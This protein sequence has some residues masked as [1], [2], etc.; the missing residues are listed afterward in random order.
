M[1]YPFAPNNDDDFQGGPKSDKSAADVLSRSRLGGAT[2]RSMK[3][4]PFEDEERQNDQIAHSLKFE[5]EPDSLAIPDSAIQKVL[6]F[7]FFP[8]HLVYFLVFYYL[9]RQIDVKAAAVSL[10][11]A[12]AIQAGLSFLIIWWTELIT[13]ALDIQSEVAG[14]SFTSIGF[15][16][17][18]AVYNL[19]LQKQQQDA[20]FLTTF[21]MIGIYKFGFAA[22]IGWLLSFIIAG[23]W[24]TDF[25]T[26]GFM[27][28]AL[29][30]VAFFAIS[31]LFIGISRAKI[32]RKM[33]L[34]YILTYIVFFIL[35]VALTATLTSI[36]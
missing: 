13:S 21:E 36:N 19:N 32:T 14:L 17:S 23:E 28:S 26:K 11:I 3:D 35:A 25:I 24:K 22:S 2:P 6:Y 27:V 9:R 10:V 29:I 12:L 33:F 16:I 4:D 18:F 20:N 7:L 15:S 34:P 31:A 1:V 30:Y 8:F 5:I